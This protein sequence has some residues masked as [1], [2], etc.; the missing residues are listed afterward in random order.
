[1]KKLLLL[2]LLPFLAR[3]QKKATY[4]PAA[5]KPKVEYSL[6]T[7]LLRLDDMRQRIDS[8][9]TF[10]E[11]NFD[12]THIRQEV[13]TLTL[14]LSQIGKRLESYQVP[15]YKQLLLYEYMLGD[16]E[17]ELAS[18]RSAL[19]R[20]N[21]VLVSLSSE[22]AS[23]SGD[24]L[25]RTVVRDSLYRQMY[26]LELRRLLQKWDTVKKNTEANLTTINSLQ[27]TIVPLYFTASDLSEKTVALKRSIAGRVLEKEYPY[28]WAPAEWSHHPISSTAG[29]YTGADSQL[30]LYFI[31]RNGSRYLY[32]LLIGIL[33]GSWVYRNYRLQERVHNED[34]NTIHDEVR[35]AGHDEDKNTVRD[36]KEGP[37][38]QPKF[39]YIRRLPFLSAVV[40][41]FNILPFFDPNAPTMFA[42]WSQ[43]ILM[44]C[45][46]ILFRTTWPRNA[47]YYWVLI[48]VLYAGYL[49]AGIPGMPEIFARI[50]LIILNLATVMLL[51]RSRSRVLPLFPYPRIV[52]FV[53]TVCQVFCLLSVL[54][55]ISG[56]MS[57]S[58]ILSSAAIYGLVQIVM[59]SVFIDSVNE[60]FTLQMIVSQGQ[61]KQKGLVPMFQ[62]M[63]KGVRRLLL[64]L[65]LI[66]LLTGFTINLSIYDA[67]RDIALRIW[68][69]VTHLGSVSF[70]TGNVVLF[71]GII[72]VANMLQKYI[73]YLYGSEGD[74]AMPQAG[75][76]GSQ[77][78]VFR[79]VFLFAG[80]LLAITASGL[81][82]D[83]ITI[84]LGALGV[85]IGLGLQNIVNNLVSGIILIFERPFQLGDY[86]ELNGKKGMVRDIGIRSSRMVTE[87]GTEIIMP[88][89]DLLAGEVINWTVKNRQVRIEL[90][91]TV[92][93]GR[94]FEEIAKLVQEA[95]AGH[96]GLSEEEK[97]Q[98]LLNA[99]KDKTLSFTVLAWVTNITQ[100]QTLK[101]EVLDS[102]YRKFATQGVKIV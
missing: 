44:I 47:F 84:V 58:G 12:T 87:D 72:Y 25:I 1:M 6:D 79:L 52:R 30:I 16:I 63:L 83:K 8:V 74:R 46:T 7:L 98:V 96:S 102:I 18:W 85:G 35:N 100:I 77:L 60:A 70:R 56:R 9:S 59:L 80:L 86:I 42:Q 23:F 45:M 88:N 2:V 13:R 69:H 78:I 64:L 31:E 65:A 36:E 38:E 11:K 49:A 61:E 67:M 94:S 95:L 15:E 48:V 50:W 73:G 75:K 68:N 28:L 4:G 55:N 29:R 91:I 17:K 33:F 71:I 40:V 97:P 32:A 82:I 53:W 19:F 26:Q 22:T 51:Y 54:C 37:A 101:S 3:A 41:I 24:S 62:R 43:F 14:R 90:P 92:E 21:A 99:S 20:Y 76:K 27:A 93:A 39:R 5:H 34:R 81:P 10:Q 57:L 66:T 89:G